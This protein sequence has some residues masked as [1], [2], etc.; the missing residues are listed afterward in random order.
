MLSGYCGFGDSCKFLHDRSDYKHGW[1]LER[2]WN[3]Q[4]YGS[5]DANS[6][7]YLID[8]K[9]TPNQNHWSSFNSNK[10]SNLPINEDDSGDDDERDEDGL[11]IKCPICR[12]T[13]REPVVTKCRHYFCESC[14]LRQYR[15]D[16]QCPVC[17]ESTNG[18]FL[19]AKD[20]V[21]KLKQV[22]QQTNSLAQ[23]P[24]ENQQDDTDEDSS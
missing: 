23:P 5:V 15:V 13:F 12:E 9:K 8:E 20:I 3:E 11:P 22:A 6:Q 18:L 17:H 10:S 14:A 2:E 19:P 16:P 1:Q 24:V 7:K 4:S 21:A